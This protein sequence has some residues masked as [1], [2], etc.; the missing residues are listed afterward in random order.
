MIAAIDGR[1]PIV[2]PTAFVVDSAVVI[3]DV[4]LG[5][6]SSLW[7]HAVVRGDVERVRI[8]ARTNIQDNA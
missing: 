1:T 2:D 6:E 3:G 5:P 7:Y 8:G 4:V